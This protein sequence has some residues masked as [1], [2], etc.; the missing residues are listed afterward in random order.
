MDVAPELVAFAA[1]DERRLRVDLE[2]REA[3]DDVDAGLFERTRPADVAMLVEAGLELDERHALLAALGSLDEGGYDGRVLARAVEGRLECDDR[4]VLCRRLQERLEGRREG[5]ERMV[6]EDV[7]LL[8][9]GEQLVC[10]GREREARMDDGK[11]RLFLQVG[12]VDRDQLLKLGKIEQAL[13]EVDLFC[14]R[15]EPAL[16]PLEHPA[17]DRA[18]DLDAHDVAEPPPPE[19][20]FDRLDEVVG[21]VRHLEVGVTRDAE[22]AAFDDLHLR[23]ES[24]KEVADHTLERQVEAALAN[25]EE[26]RAGAPGP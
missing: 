5:V 2:I 22:G 10:V 26:A 14:A 7:A 17:R 23:E 16:E 4:R 18:R 20:V 8:D 9:L 12:A 13:D 25:R 3:V 6:D 24:G 19:L 21:L 15:A 1:D 11:P